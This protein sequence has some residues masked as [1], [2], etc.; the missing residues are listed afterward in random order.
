[1]NKKRSNS[2]KG[3]KRSKSAGKAVILLSGG[4][5]SATTLYLAKK[6]GY[7]LYALIFNY[8]QRHSKE[9][10]CAVD[11]ANLNRVSYYVLNLSLPWTQSA[12]TKRNIEVPL[13][14]SL[15][16]K[17]IP[18]TYVSGRNIIFLSYA[19]SFA[20]S[21]N[22]KK[23]FIG[24]HI[25]DYSGYPDCRP[26]F[27]SAMEHAVNEGIAHRGIEIVAPLIDKSKKDIVKL[28]IELGVPFERTWSCYTGGRYPCGKCDSCRFRIRAFESLG[29]V[30]PLLKKTKRQKQAK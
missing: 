29:M 3:I 7:S 9:I 25:E 2:A 8:K 11:I 15:S 18:V 27:L 5:D 10:R 1:M 17:G 14:R 23:I 26:Q 6:S 12:L 30:D 4:L 24:A 13:N 28:G 19:V 20:E 21:I 16:R 22:A